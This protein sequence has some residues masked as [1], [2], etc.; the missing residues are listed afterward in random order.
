MNK[1]SGKRSDLNM[2]WTYKY[3]QRL[4]LLGMGRVGVCGFQCLKQYDPLSEDS[5]DLYTGCP[6]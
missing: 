1:V 6:N 3:K 5:I 4:F 2:N